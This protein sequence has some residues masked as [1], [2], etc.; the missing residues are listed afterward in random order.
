MQKTSSNKL[1][2]PPGKYHLIVDNTSAGY[3]DPPSNLDDD[4]AE[5]EV[6]IEATPI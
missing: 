2:L 3:A 6:S 5:V 1:E 4:L